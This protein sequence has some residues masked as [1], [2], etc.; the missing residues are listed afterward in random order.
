MG[1]FSLECPLC[2]GP[3]AISLVTCWACY[4]KH[5]LK[6]GNPQCEEVI[7]AREA[8]LCASRAH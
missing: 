2:N 1:R 5:G 8:E 6:Y 3:K 7:E 4:R